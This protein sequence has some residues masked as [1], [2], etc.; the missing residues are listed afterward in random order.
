MTPRLAG[1]GFAVAVTTAVS[2]Q[3]PAPTFRAQVEAVQVDAFVTDRDGNPVRDLRLEDFELFEDGRLQTITSFSEVII[4]ITAPAPFLPGTPR[5]DVATNSGGEGRLYVIAVDEIGADL[6]LRARHFLTTFIERHFEPNDVGVVVNVGRALSTAGQDFTSDRG[7]LLAAIN[8]LQGGFGVVPGEPGELWRPDRSSLAQRSRAAALKALIASLARIGGRRKALIYITQEVGD[9]YDVID[10]KGGVRS[11]EFDDLRAAMTEAMRGGVAFYTIDPCGLTT[12]GALGETEGNVAGVCDAD[13]ERMAAFRKLSEATG[14]FAV[15]NSNSFGQALERMVKEN[16]NYYLLGFTSTNGRRDGR[17]RRLEVRAKR[18]GLTVRARDGYIA[19]S[20]SPGRSVDTRTNATTGIRNVINS[21]LSNGA[22][23]MRV[24]AAAFRGSK[25][26]EA[27]VVITAEFDASGL[28]LA[29]TGGTMRAQIELASA[30]VSAAGK[31]TRGQ[32]QV[33][34][35]TLKPDS[36]AQALAHGFRTQA[37][38]TLPPGRYQL[39][40]AGGNTQAAKI[41]SVMYDLDVPDFRKGRLALSA[42]ALSTTEADRPVTVIPTAAN[43]LPFFPTL[44]RAFATGTRISLYVEVYDNADG[45]A[46]NPIEL[47]VEV[48][49]QH[50]QIVRSGSD[51]RT[52]MTKGTETFVVALPLDVGAGDY[53]LHIEAASGGDSISRDIPVRVVQ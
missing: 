12:G 36:Y 27:K 14:G 1:L 22:V 30:A 51:R 52:R 24:V 26:N 53:S 32:P 38:I 39:R 45:R 10:Y 9:V 28:G 37:A 4:P 2:A 46:R 3:Q 25:G 40:V 16:S 15:V 8:R 18:P 50:G 6:A 29:A 5:P 21:P 44:S 43:A 23:P 11:L 42:V 35:L 7:L 17:Y 34:D 49:D 33:I 48:R 19:P 47:K 31:V 13:L 41:G 20:G